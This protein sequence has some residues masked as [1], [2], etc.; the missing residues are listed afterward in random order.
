[1]ARAAAR[2]TAMWRSSRNG[3]SVESSAGPAMAAT[4]STASRRTCHAGSVRASII[5]LDARDIRFPTSS[6]L[7]G[8]DAM[9]PSPD[10]SCAY[11]VLYTDSPDG[12]E[13]HGLTFTNGRGTEVVVAA[14]RL[15][16][17]G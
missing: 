15:A 9:H 2:R 10:Y 3:R 5:A 12:L 4:Y 17:G 16:R 8:S 11:A 7:D 14:V 6:S 13:G 1:M